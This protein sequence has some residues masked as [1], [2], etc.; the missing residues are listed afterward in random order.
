MSRQVSCLWQGVEN[1]CC[2]ITGWGVASV[3]K[4][5]THRVFLLCISVWIVDM[6]ITS[7]LRW[8]MG[9]EWGLRGT[10]LQYQGA[11]FVCIQTH[12]YCQISWSFQRY[13]VQRTSSQKTLS[14]W[15]HFLWISVFVL[16]F[17]WDSEWTVKNL[18]PGS[19][20]KKKN[21]YKYV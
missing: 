1:T 17:Q 10:K 2:D 18:F 14:N 12:I 19:T 9:F 11:N 15:E 4:E 7:D 13:Q 6:E 20:F 3:A 16:T 8:I 21:Q 5:S